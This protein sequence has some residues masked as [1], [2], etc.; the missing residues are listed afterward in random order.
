[1][2]RRAPR[3][4]YVLLFIWVAISTAYYIAGTAA[5]NEKWFHGERYGT[6]PFDVRNGPILYDVG[7]EARAAGLSD[8]DVLETLNGRPFTGDFQLTNYSTYSKPGDVWHVSVRRP[9]GQI[10]NAAV[11]LKPLQGPGFSVGGYVAYLGAVL[12]VTLL[13]LVVGYWVVVARPTDHNAWLVLILLTLQETAFGDIAAPWWG[14]IWYVV[15]GF[16]SLTVGLWALPALFWFGLFFPERGRIDR[17]WPALKWI[18]L[19]TQVYGFLLYLWFGYLQGFDIARM[20]RFIGVKWWT[21]QIIGGGQ[22]ACIIL[23]LVAI[24]DKLRSASTPDARRRLRVLAIGSGLSLVPLLIMFGVLP[25]FGYSFHRGFLFSISIPFF[26]LFPLTLAYVLI[27]QRA[28]DLR[29][30]VRMGTKYLLAQATLNGL[31]VLIA[32]FLVLRFIVPMIQQKQHQTTNLILVGAIIGLLLWAFAGSNSLSNR[33]QKWLDRKF[34]REAYDAEVVLSELS[35]HARK[36]TEKGPLLE[37]V[38][39]RIS[40]VLHVP[41][42]AVWLRQ[43]STFHLQ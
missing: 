42:V 16:W 31:L 41:Q 12:G 1:M 24:F 26:I 9:D 3:G 36:L 11:K 32:G 28:M 14:G 38:S 21:D 20:P 7:K 39:R 25:F 18:V 23:F 29:V 27:V 34:F 33:L 30:L 15:F 8:G 17:R 10:R 5:L 4:L 22:A 13:C 37:T 2:T 6:P 40:E 43:S 19:A 35:E